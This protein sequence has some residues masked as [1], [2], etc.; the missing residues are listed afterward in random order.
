MFW[1]FKS[2]NFLRLPQMM[3]RPRRRPNTTTTA[4]TRSLLSSTLLTTTLLSSTHAI[5]TQLRGKTTMTSDVI[6]HLMGLPSTSSSSSTT[7]HPSATHVATPLNPPQPP[8]NLLETESLV[9]LLHRKLGGFGTSGSSS[10]KED[11]PAIDPAAIAMAQ[12]VQASMA[13][14]QP[15]AHPVN[16]AWNPLNQDHTPQAATN[17][18]VQ[19]P[20]DPLSNNQQQ[21]LSENL[22]GYSAFPQGTAPGESLVELNAATHANPLV[23]ETVPMKSPD[24]YASQVL[25]APRG[26]PVANP[27][28]MAGTSVVQHPALSNI[29][30][31]LQA[32][33]FG[34]VMPDASSF[35]TN[36]LAYHPSAQVSATKNNSILKQHN[37]Q[38]HFIDT[39]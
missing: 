39:H 36:P 15:I 8:T 12:T 28:I 31:G 9:H 23:V 2:G 16:S 3:D 18:V 26:Q 25:A 19:L 4:F 38:D 1:G 30:E 20:Y 22:G 24:E 34:A 5:D 29:K 6:A 14:G 11:K 33:P 13:Y 27:S 10:K 37:A 35:A 32:N 21:D 7:A 17:Q